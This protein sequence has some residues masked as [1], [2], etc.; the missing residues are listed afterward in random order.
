MKLVRR[1]LLLA[2]L[3]LAACAMPAPLAPPFPEKRGERRLVVVFANNAGSEPFNRQMALMATPRL[4][5]FDFDLVEAVGRG[6]IRVNGEP[7]PTPTVDELANAYRVAG[8]FAVRLI[9]RQ[10]DVRL[11]LNRPLT[12][13]ELEAAVETWPEGA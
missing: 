10:G 6:P 1:S 13:P 2:P 3:A 4:R 12:F 7:R 8:A 11:A 5:N 9:D